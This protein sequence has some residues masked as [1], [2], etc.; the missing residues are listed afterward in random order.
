MKLPALCLAATFA[1]GV[2][3]GLFSPLVNFSTSVQANRAAFFLALML[4]A[5]CLILL[6]QNLIALAATLSLGAWLSLGVIARGARRNL[7]LKIM[8]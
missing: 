6:R 5:V 7:D 2:A 4:L 1:G 3:L 8:S